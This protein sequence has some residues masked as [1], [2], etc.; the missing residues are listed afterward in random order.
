MEYVDYYDFLNEDAEAEREVTE[1][2]SRI[3]KK[4]NK[5]EKTLL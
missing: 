5:T 4:D 3:L 2:I 1:E